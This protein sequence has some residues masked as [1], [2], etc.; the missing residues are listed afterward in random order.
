[1]RCHAR[2]PLVFHPG[3]SPPWPDKHR[4]PMWKFRDLALQLQADGLVHASPASGE[5]PFLRPV[6]ALEEQVLLAHDQDYYEGFCTNSLPAHLWRRIGF[7]QRPCHAQL[8]QR[9]QLEV[10][11]T[12]LAARKALERGMAGNL[13]G[14][15]HHAHRAYGS[16][17]TA[18]ND[19]EITA[20]VL[21]KEEAVAR[22]LIC[23]LDVH[24]GDGT[25][26]ILKEEPRAFTMSVHCK[27]NFPFGFKGMSHLGHDQSD[28]DVALPKGTADAVYLATVFEHLQAVLEDFRPEL[29]LYDAGVDVHVEDDLG[30]FCISW[31]GLRKREEMVLQLCVSKGIPIAFVIG[32][33]YHRHAK[34][35]SPVLTL[36]RNF[37]NGNLYSQTPCF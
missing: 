5:A 18:L 10:S 31:D 22:L 30:N 21:L 26:E 8:V 33:G 29:V 14:G 4:F 1:M 32:G 13:A 36:D 3:Y 9:T 24:Q 35:L 6:K 28:W 11:G 12:L 25:A 19:L 16:G 2:L 15:T 17:Y 20:K 27:D 7:T 37:G 34:H 23:D